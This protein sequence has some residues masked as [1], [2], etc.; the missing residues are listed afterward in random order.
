M[1]EIK[2]I[3]LRLGEKDYEVKEAGFIV[4]KP[5]KKKLLE[6]IKP[7][8]EML[9]G[10]LDIE[11]S[12]PADLFKLLP[13]AETILVDGVEKILDAIIGYSVVLQADHEYIINNATDRQIVAAFREVVLL[14]D[15]FGVVNQ[16]NKQI[17]RGLSGI[18]SNLQQVSGDAA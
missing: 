8:F 2:T 14:A 18:S 11:F 7:L 16:L 13:L 17:G 15:P 12:T 4:S 5:W 3:T 6:E 9:T 10:G 1:I